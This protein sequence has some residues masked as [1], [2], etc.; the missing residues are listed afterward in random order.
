MSKSIFQI[1]VRVITIITIIVNSY[2]Y[3]YP[4]LNK[5]NCSWKCY[6]K[7]EE[8]LNFFEKNLINYI[9]I[10]GDLYYQYYIPEDISL[11]PSEPRDIRLLA[12]GDP[13]INGNWPKT[14]YIKRLDNFGNDYYIGHIYNVM[15]N[16]LRPTHVTVMGDLFSS[17]WI[18]D[19]EFFNRTRRYMTRLFP[20]P[21]QETLEQFKVIDKHQT[22]D[23]RSHKAWFK[24]SLENGLFDSEEFYH[25]EDVYNWS[26]DGE[27]DETN[28]LFINIT[29]NHDIGYGDSTYQHMTRWRK[30]FGKENFWIEFDNGKE[31]AYRI[32]VLNSLFLDGPLM[33][34]EFKQ[35]TW[36]FI[37]V[38]N[39][40]EYN[41]SS[42]LFTHIP[43]YKRE[44]LCVDGPKFELYTKE[45][46]LGGEFRI[47]LLKSQNHLSYETSQRVMNAIFKDNGKSG[48]IMTGHDH[49]GCQ[50]YYNFE[51]ESNE[52]VASKEIDSDRYIKEITVRA[53]MGDYDGVTGLMTG[54]FNHQD[55]NWEYNYSE[56]PFIIQHVWWFAK[57]G[58]IL[59]V[60][61]QSISFLF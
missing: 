48:I 37:E 16:R 14:K 15:K 22:L 54:H 1:S 58:A 41:G 23:F 61:L 57:I 13:Q 52:W 18:L 39:K 20:R 51:N 50:N 21:Q 2:I 45:T 7:N 40:R 9:P 24:E 28:P 34:D 60:L 31:S 27:F 38:L 59:T 56:C 6:Y 33:H 26:N 46:C 35:A 42:I 12:I 30:L 44:G 10:I 32:I 49:E 4:T 8:N 36:K 47:G 3:L 5:E 55:K 11:I 29:G 53:I 43:M 19:S 25:Y 17:Q